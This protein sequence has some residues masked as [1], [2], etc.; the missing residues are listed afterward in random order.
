M[1]RDGSR[2]EDTV[3]ARRAL[4]ARPTTGSM[5]RDDILSGTSPVLRRQ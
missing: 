3:V 2:G 4:A 1:A 5:A